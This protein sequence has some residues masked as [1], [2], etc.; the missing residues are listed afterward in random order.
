MQRPAVALGEAGAP[1]ALVAFLFWQSVGATVAESFDPY[2]AWLG[3][4]TKGRAPNHYTLLG[5]KLFVADPDVIA[6][7]ADTV[8]AKVRGIRPGEHAAEW[9]QVLDQIAKAKTCLL[10]PASKKVY[11]EKLEAMRA[12]R[13]AANAGATMAKPPASSTPAAAKSPASMAVSAPAKASPRPTPAKTAS[14]QDLPLGD[15]F[16]S[17]GNSLLDEAFQAAPLLEVAPVPITATKK[18]KA[19]FELPPVALWSIF[20]TLALVLLVICY[21][22]FLRG[23]AVASPPVASP[24]FAQVAMRPEVPKPEPPKP[25]APTAVVQPPV[26]APTPPAPR[27]NRPAPSFGESPT[28]TKPATPPPSESKQA[29]PPSEAKQATPP[30]KAK[31]APSQAKTTPPPSFDESSKQG[32]GHLKAQA[33]KLRGGNGAAGKNRVAPKSKESVKKAEEKASN[34]SPEFLKAIAATRAALA[35]RNLAAAKSQLAIADDEANSEEEKN[36]VERLQT[37]L[38]NLTQFWNGIRQSMPK[39]QAAEEIVIKDTRIVVVDATRELMTVKV[40]GRVHRFKIETLPTSLVMVMV[41][42]YFGKDVGSK[43]VI[44]TFLA[45]DPSGDRK[46]AKQYFQEAADDGIDTEKLLPEVDAMPPVIKKAG[47]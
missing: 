4:P 18:Q 40:E 14:A 6:K 16:E 28:Q 17:S 5:L 23:S 44:G 38:E 41:D 27:E 15:L 35:R 2:A 32:E 31:P 7:A 8:R 9:S 30:S 13:A 26:A 43:A 12:A 20:G 33:A 11:D 42:R 19:L 34:S 45:V 46:L 3:L 47:R 24:H 10:D 21:F 1:V 22:K 25:P 37:M 39:F 29:T 36:V